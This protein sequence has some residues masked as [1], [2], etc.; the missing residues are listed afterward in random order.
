MNVIDVDNRDF[1]SVYDLVSEE[2]RYI[3]FDFSSVELFGKKL[4]ATVKNIKLQWDSNIEPDEIFSAGVKVF[5]VNHN[6]NFIIR[7][8]SLEVSRLVT[9]ISKIKCIAIDLLYSTGKEFS[10]HFTSGFVIW[11]G[12]LGLPITSRPYQYGFIEPKQLKLMSLT[13]VELLLAGE[14]WY[15][16]QLL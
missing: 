1:Y 5:P 4:Q 7:P 13:E 3:E 15:K 12:D 10:F 6:P 14:S 9:S 2:V 8:T 11:F 16:Y